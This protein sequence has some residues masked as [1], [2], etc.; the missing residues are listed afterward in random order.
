[1]LEPLNNLMKQDVRWNWSSSQQGAFEAAK[2]CITSAPVLVFYNPEKPVTLENDASE[3]G[4]GSALL[5][6]KKPIAFASRSLT[7]CERK[8][9]QIE[10]EMLALVYGLEKFHHYTFGRA[11]HI[12]TDHKPLV[13]IANKPLSKAPRRLQN[14]L[15]RAQKY[16]FTLEWQ[17]STSIPVADTLSRAPAENVTNTEEVHTVKDYRK[18]DHRLDIIRSA[19]VADQEMKILSNV[20]MAGWPNDRHDVPPEARPYFDY[21]DELTV[22][23]GI[24]YW[25]DRIVVPKSMRLEMKQKVHIGHLGINFCLRRAR[26][27]I[28]WPGMS[29]EIWNYIETC[30]TCATYGVK[31][32]TESP[33]IS[34]QPDRPWSKVASDLFSYGGKT[35][36]VTVD[37]YSNF[38]EVDHLR[39]E[40]SFTVICKLKA[41]FA[42]QGIPDVLVTDNGSQFTSADFKQFVKSWGFE[43]RTSSPGYPQANGF[44]EDAVKVAKSIMRK[45]TSTNDDYFLGLLNHRN[46]PSV[47]L[48]TSPAQRLMGRR[49]KT[50]LPS[51]QNQLI[52][53]NHDCKKNVEMRETM[54]IK[55]CEISSHKKDLMPLTPGDNVRMEPLVRGE[56]QLVAARYS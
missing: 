13:A 33:M 5:Q 23:D 6:D 17:P 21:R 32:P 51:T 28:F 38:I 43:H 42:R 16:R 34:E 26:N 1:M 55:T 7:E 53:M 45:S 15:L 22:Q 56:R 12:I 29:F 2:S 9:A 3:Y 24:V 54:R 27:T 8:Y 19:T 40:N 50:T 18:K 10:K 11:V 44:A 41:H 4:L 49:T 35:F 46:T 36:L 48:N 25:G 14:L 30:G 37:C 52:P 20:I 39:N 31:Q 47:G